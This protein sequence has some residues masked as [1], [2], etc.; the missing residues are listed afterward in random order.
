MEGGI[1]ASVVLEP[2]AGGTAEETQE[3]KGVH[4]QRAGTTVSPARGLRVDVCVLA[5][6]TCAQLIA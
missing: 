3:S 4:G 5:L 6:P 2:G 1:I